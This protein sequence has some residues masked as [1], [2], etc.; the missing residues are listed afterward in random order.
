MQRITILI[1]TRNRLDRLYKTLAS[2][3]SDRADVVV[4]TDGD[5]VTYDAMVNGGVKCLRSPSHVGSVAC[6]NMALRTL[7]M[8]GCLYATDDVEFCP[9][10]LDRVMLLFNET[11]ENDDGVVGLKQDQDHHP[12]GVALVGRAFLDRYPNHQLF[13]PAYY[14]FSAQEVYWYCKELEFRERRCFF[15]QDDQVS[16]IH[17]HPSVYKKLVDQTHR[18]ARKYKSRDMKILCGR[19]LMGEVWPDADTA[20]IYV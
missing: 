4:V 9:D 8:D 2:I 14:H 18:D 11:F 16:L 10:A 19:D 1:P 12:T 5:D 13:F 3:D 7:D 15:V 20:D 6:R 17:K